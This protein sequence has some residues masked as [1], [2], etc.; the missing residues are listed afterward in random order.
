MSKDRRPTTLEELSVKLD[1][2]MKRLDALEDIIL[3]N[4]DYSDLAS[5]LRLARASIG[6]YGEPLK[7]LARL[8][9][10]E[11]YVKHKTVTQDGISRCIIQSLAVRGRLNISALTRQVHAMRGRSSRRIIRQ[12][13]KR[14]EKENIVHKVEG[15]GN[16]Y[17]LV[18]ASDQ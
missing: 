12:R 4:P 16:T 14:L 9:A 15:L 1:L 6:L 7:M 13:L 11:R 17:D 3:G 8:K 5:S 10:A 2:I 18:E